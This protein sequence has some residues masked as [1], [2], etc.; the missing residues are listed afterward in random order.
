VTLAY[1]LMSW[2]SDCSETKREAPSIV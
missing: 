1:K 2:L